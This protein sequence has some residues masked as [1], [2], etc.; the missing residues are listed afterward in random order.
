MGVVNCNDE[1]F[2]LKSGSR[3]LR[4]QVTATPLRLVEHGNARVCVHVGVGVRALSHIGAASGGWK[5]RRH[6]IHLMSLPAN[7]AN[8]TG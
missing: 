6:A 2:M 8:S 7:C 1:R 5:C 4:A 3:V